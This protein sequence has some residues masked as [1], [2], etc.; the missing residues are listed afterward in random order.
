MKKTIV[1]LDDHFKNF[2]KK[3]EIWTTFLDKMKDKISYFPVATLEDFA[4][5]LADRA[6]YNVGQEGYI[7]ALLLDVMLSSG[8]QRN[9]NFGK[10][11][12]PDDKLL[13]L[14]AGAQILGFIHNPSRCNDRPDWLNTYQGRP[15][16]LFTSY[17]TV[18][19]MWQ[20]HIDLSITK[21]TKLYNALIKNDII[22]QFKL[23]PDQDFKAW[24]ES[25]LNS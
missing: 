8:M 2:P 6:N 22:G 17:S 10:L 9:P 12:F 14:E 11:G 19:S 16:A 7:D 5:F 4:D 15:T 23:E 20:G 25:I 1:W 24:V 3:L 18:K 13:S 21:N